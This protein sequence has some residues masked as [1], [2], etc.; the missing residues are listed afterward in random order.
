MPAEEP[1]TPRAQAN[2][3]VQPCGGTQ[4]LQELNVRSAPCGQW[5]VGIF[6][7]RIEEWTN[8]KTGNK[9]ASFR[10]LLVSLS[11]PT[12]YLAA[13]VST[14]EGHLP[15]LKKAEKRYAEKLLFRISKVSLLTENKQQFL[16]CPLKWVV[17]LARTQTDPLMAGT[18]GADSLQPQPPMTLS[19]VRELTHTQRFD[20]TALVANVDENAREV[21]LGRKVINVRLLDASGPDKPQ[22]VPFGFFFD[23]PPNKATLATMDIL[24]SGAILSFFALQGKRTESGFSIES[25]K[26]FFVIEAVGE[27]AAQL[28]AVSATLLQT[29]Q[30]ERACLPVHA[31][32]G[33]KTDY[34]LLPGKGEFLQDHG[35]PQRRDRPS[36]T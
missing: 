32:S 24:R 16:H 17:D 15:P 35:W 31:G 29:K 33:G 1:Q 9:G 5:D 28:K 3:A 23:D 18:C 26:D 27:R 30:D 2:S 13:Q 12:S 20:V 25:S 19:Q 14:R 4:R 7:S 6:R 34:S 8:P 36:G 22:E 11:D 10:C 21:K